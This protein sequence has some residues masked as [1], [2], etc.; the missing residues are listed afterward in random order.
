MSK[1]PENEET[2]RRHM[3]LKKNYT[4]SGLPLR[5]L[6]YPDDADN[7]PHYLEKLGFP[8]QY[9]FTRG[10]YPEM[11]R[12]RLWTSRLATGFGDAI[13]TNQRLHTLLQAGQTGVS[14]AFDLGTLEGLDA[15]HYLAQPEFGRCGV[16][17]STIDDMS[18]L[19]EGIDLNQFSVSLNSNATTPVLLALF[20][21]AAERQ[22][23]QPSALRGTTQNDPL[24]EIV[25]QNEFNFQLHGG[26]RLV[27]DTLEYATQ[28]LPHW[29][30][31]NVS[32][33]HIREA[34][35]NAIEELAFTLANGLA[36]V[37]AGQERGLLVD[38]F[39]SR[40]SF[41]F[42]VGNDFFEEIAKFRAA[43]RIWA[44]LMRERG[45]TV[46]RSLMLKFHAHTSGASLTAQEPLNNVSRVSLQALAAVLGGAQSLHTC[47]FDEALALPTEMAANVALATQ[48]II[49]QESGVAHVIDP[50]GGSYFIEALTDQF[51]A[52]TCQV[53]SEVE[54]LGGAV[55][56]VESGYYLE[57]IRSSA[58]ARYAAI[59]KGERQVVGINTPGSDPLAR[60]PVPLQRAFSAE[61]YSRHYD[62]LQRAKYSRNQ[63]QVEKL[64]L[65][66]SDDIQGS[67]N[68]MPRLIQLAKAGATVGE[69]MSVLKE[70][71]GEFPRELPTTITSTKQTPEQP[72]TQEQER[73]V[74]VLMA[75]VGLDGHD[76]GARYVAQLL[77]EAGMEVVYTGKKSDIQTV[78]KLLQEQPI[79]VLG[80]S[81][82]SGIH[83]QIM[84]ELAEEIN[85][86]GL[87][88]KIRV[89]F[90]GTIPERDIPHLQQFGA[91]LVVTPGTPGEEII[92]RIF[93]LV[94]KP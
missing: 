53:M 74:R 84:R 28:H 94:R 8:G 45:A 52:E 29:N 80:I 30:V 57:R 1:R 22:G 85:Q 75:K 62:R 82:Q 42:N 40:M 66:L 46:D 83:M 31:V 54:A 68:V 49:A 59:E 55:Q 70:S 43:R 6:Y 33:Y 90:G 88:G 5:A 24:K 44:R 91:D 64:L 73:P 11:Y 71:F 87:T 63:R 39:V 27:T 81:A 56:A 86:L 20:I 51:E 4:E 7:D 16:A 78:V 92:S 72:Q 36:Y 89:V 77:A 38:D 76:V 65:S 32:G 60:Q 3:D 18:L 19:F 35:A 12:H 26:M 37:K 14:I 58:Q 50:L 25:S 67:V 9:P 15:D 21:A 13:D 10:I 79:D 23:V 2:A 47:S 34:G 48:M 93:A 61:S 69:M 41:Y 17:V